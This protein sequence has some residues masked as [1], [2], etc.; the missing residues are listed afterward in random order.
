MLLSSFHGWEEWGS[1]EYKGEFYPYLRFPYFICYGLFNIYCIKVFILKTE[2]FDTTLHF[3]P[4]VS[5]SLSSPKSW[6]WSRAL[7]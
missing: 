7:K 2:V 5:T 6:L 1:E 4:E 3:V